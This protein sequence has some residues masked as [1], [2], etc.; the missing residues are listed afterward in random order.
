MLMQLRDFNGLTISRATRIVA[1]A[2]LLGLLAACG[3]DRIASPPVA[4]TID[5]LAPKT[6]IEVGEP[7]TLSAITRDARDSV[8]A[9]AAVTWSVS[10]AGVAT[11]NDGVVTGVA[12]GTATVQ[13][14]LQSASGSIVVNVV[15]ASVASVSLSA[16]SATV[17]AGSTVMVAAVV[18]DARQTPL[19]NRAITWSSSDTRRV[20]VSAEGVA[21]AVSPGTAYVVA[22]SEGVADSLLL[23][24]T[25][26]AGATL[27]LSPVD[28]QVAVGRTRFLTARVRDA[29]GNVRYPDEVTWT[30][31]NPGIA[32]VAGGVVT[33]VAPGAVSVRAEAGGL[34]ALSSIRV[35][36]TQEGISITSTMN[37]SE[38]VSIVSSGDI[39]VSGAIIAPCQ[40]IT[41]IAGGR[42]VLTAAAASAQTKLDNT[43][44]TPDAAPPAIHIE[45]NGG[46]ELTYARVRSSGDITITN[47][48]GLVPSEF[49]GAPIARERVDCVL[50]NSSI[51]QATPAAATA[52]GAAGRDGGHVDVACR[53]SLRTRISAITAQG[54]G[55]GA[56]AEHPLHATGGN[57]GRSGTI[58]FRVTGDLLVD[59]RRLNFR[60]MSSG[61]GGSASAVQGGV[62][63]ASATAAGG[64]GGDIGAPDLPPIEFRV[65]GDVTDN[66]PLNG[67]VIEMGLFIAGVGGDAAATA[68]A[69]ADATSV[70]SAAAGGA[71]T[72]IGGRGGFVYPSIVTV[73]GAIGSLDLL[74]LGQGSGRGGNASAT[75]GNGG[76][77]SSA[78]PNGAPG[79]AVRAEGGDGGTTV[80]VNSPGGTPAVGGRG[81]LATLS[82]GAGGAG[83]DRCSP[84]GVGGSGGVGG[85]VAGG[86]G[87]GG[88]GQITTAAH[89]GITITGAGSGGSGGRGSTP[90][91]GGA[92][93]ADE[94]RT[95]GERIVSPSS[96]LTGASGGACP[97]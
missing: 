38:P 23:T 63:G 97:P 5:V 81:G 60:I 87:R 19:S 8:I 11:V 32:T 27:E 89:G 48:A 18:R 64:R 55:N 90:G 33:A 62:D 31:L 67:N 40:P 83:F 17:A 77:G 96:F 86:D 36:A 41:L 45:A 22:R 49:V 91:A 73:G 70:A 26:G 68:A 35:T 84:P 37:A 71:A 75:G 61:N 10:P 76:G 13:A 6:T 50:S 39:V 34:T 53:G 20:Q 21:T 24:V 46:Y 12:P 94:T 51:D 28:V 58:R 9:D 15:P 29:S 7:L 65:A 80:G 88:T 30:S 79:G 14:T 25:F 57:G 43:C 82:G 72:A 92:P 42:V 93:G 4:A 3:D 47:D 52:G 44:A 16:P 95:L 85:R 1:P 66:D 56:P 59:Q 74:L 78:F 54:G 2:V 69:G